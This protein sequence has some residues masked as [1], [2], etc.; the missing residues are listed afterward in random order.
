MT[1][2]ASTALLMALWGVLGVL[3]GPRTVIGPACVLL[4]ATPLPLPRRAAAPV[5]ETE[6][7]PSHS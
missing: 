2:T 6:S 1:T 3:P 4:L 5:A 7:A